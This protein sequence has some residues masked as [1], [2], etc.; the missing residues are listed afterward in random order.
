MYA[1]HSRC[2][3]VSCLV[4]IPHRPDLF[5]AKLSDKPQKLMFEEQREMVAEI[6]QGTGEF[7]RVKAESISLKFSASRSG[8]PTKAASSSASP[9]GKPARPPSSPQGRKGFRLPHVT[10]F[11]K[12]YV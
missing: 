12:D 7:Y 6:G 11:G 9:G 4:V 3:P 1:S 8:T 5:L 2:I 10:K